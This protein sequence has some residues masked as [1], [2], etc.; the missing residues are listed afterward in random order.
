MA[1]NGGQLL[2]LHF[3]FSGYLPA[4]RT[5]LTPWQNYVAA[6]DV[7]LVVLDANVTSINVAD[8]STVQ[9]ARG[10]PVRARE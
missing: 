5:V 3:A 9:I 1:V 6:S 8:T 10:S 2:R 4:E 7:A